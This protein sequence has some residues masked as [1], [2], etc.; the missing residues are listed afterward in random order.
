MKDFLHDRPSLAP[1]K[2]FAAPAASQPPGAFRSFGRMPLDPAITG[3]EKPH[4]PCKDG[5]PH[6][7]TT[8]ANGRIEQII[9]TCSCGERITL[10]CAY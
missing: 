8:E 10:Q 6:I 5:A 1:R 2:G 9:V 7:E 4:E 3:E